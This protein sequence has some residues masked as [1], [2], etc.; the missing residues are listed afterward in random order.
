M[1]FESQQDNGIELGAESQAAR[2]LG[3]SGE[4]TSRSRRT[5]G[6]KSA[7]SRRL[8]G[9]LRR[10]RS[11]FSDL[12]AAGW[13]P[14]VFGM[15]LGGG[16]EA[17]AAGEVCAALSGGCKGHAAAGSVP[18]GLGADSPCSAE[19]AADSWT[20]DSVARRCGTEEG[21]FPRRRLPGEVGAVWDAGGRTRGSPSCGWRRSRRYD[22]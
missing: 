3:G 12:G 18:E 21:G 11:R 9:D 14:E 5:M 8:P 19:K 4:G 15:R 13:A 6:S 2:R 1:A 17:W 7:R 22:V 16:Y 10:G 20:R